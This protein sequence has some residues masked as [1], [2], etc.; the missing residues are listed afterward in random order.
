MDA[1][2][3]LVATYVDA[4]TLTVQSTPGTGIAIT[5]DKTDITGSANGTTD[6]TRQYTNS[7][8]VAI[9]APRIVGTRVFDK[10]I[11]DSVD[12]TTN[13]T[14]SIDMSASHTL[15]ASYVDSRTLTVQSSPDTGIA[16]TV[17]KADINGSANGTTDFTRQ[18]TNS[19]TVNLT[20]PYTVGTKVFQKW[21]Q[22]GTDLTTNLTASVAMSAD[23]TLVATY[24]D[25]RTLTVQSTPDS[26]V[27]ITVSQA[28]ITGSANGSTAFTRTY[29]NGPTVDITAPYIVGTRVFQKWTQ[30]AADL[31]TNLTASVNMSADH[32]LVAV[33]TDSRTLSIQSSPDAG[34]SITVGTTDIYGN[35]DGSTAFTRTY[36]NSPTVDITAPYI[37]GTKVF[38][39]WTQ[40]GVDLTTN[41]TASVSAAADHTLIAYYVDTKTLTV[42]STPD[43]GIAITVSK[44][45]INGN[46]NGSTPFTRQY[47]NDSLVDVTAPYI[48]GTRVFQK[49]T[50]G[51]S[52]LTTNLTVSVTMSAD[53]TIVATYVPGSRHHS[54]QGRYQR[55]SRWIDNIFQDIHQL[56]GSRYHR[57]ALRRH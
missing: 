3:T 23:H 52:D 47:T 30:D 19:P 21:V 16:I 32:T 13:L 2:H 6:F 17:D 49:W 38:S 55:R 15:V 40:D 20:A 1:N 29:T 25:A 33:Y 50:E 46:N 24:V 57:P 35:D 54:Q 12:L 26:G 10:W 48:S 7:P 42:Q 44:T 27:S 34:V 28:D 41:L 53:H 31:T 11:Q 22:D 56:S 43:S 4:R 9:T 37:V 8:T 39:R 5:V 36:T 14:A 18:Y 45:D 51:G